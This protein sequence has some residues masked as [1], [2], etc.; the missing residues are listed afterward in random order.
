MTE[1]L[2]ALFQRLEQTADDFW[3]VSRENAQ[4]LGFLTR[5]VG[6]HRVLEVGTS[7]GYSTLWFAKALQ[8]TGGHIDS[9]EFDPGRYG[10]AKEH[11]AQSGLAHCITLH[12]GDALKILPT[13]E[14]PYDLAFI[15]ADKPQYLAYTHLIL[16][17]L[18]PGGLL[19][20]DDTLSLADKMQDYL[21]FVRTASDLHTV[22]LSLD[23]GVT[24][25]IKQPER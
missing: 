2:N 23:D 17:M 22:D 24:L 1:N 16:P 6:A 7:N 8:E 15:D 11:V 20:G 9:I 12:H 5:A 3:N 4:F 18:R 25:S 10:K 19:I 14:G 21:Q 13:L